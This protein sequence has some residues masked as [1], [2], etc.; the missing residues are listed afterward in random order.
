MGSTPTPASPWIRPSRLSA[1]RRSR[2][3]GNCGMSRSAA[4]RLS[5]ATWMPASARISRSSSQACG[6]SSRAI[7]PCRPPG[8]RTHW[9]HQEARRQDHGAGRPVAPREPRWEEPAHTAGSAYFITRREERDTMSEQEQ[10]MAA[11]DVPLGPAGG[12]TPAPP[13]PQPQAISDPRQIATVVMARMNL[14]NTKKD[15]LTIAIKGLTDLTQQLVQAYAGQMQ[16]IEQ[17]AARL[18]AMEETNGA[19][20][21]NGL[22]VAPGAP[23]A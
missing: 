3:P 8:R 21:V 6:R 23:S 16:L 22:A 11:V 10:T 17:L 5:K 1:R 2:C 4:T 9:R 18:K 14:I 7:S 13:R 12:A 20:G 19:K 15:E